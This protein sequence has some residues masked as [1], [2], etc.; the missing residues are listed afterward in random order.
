MLQ[1]KIGQID[2]YGFNGREH[3]PAE[4]D[5]GLV[6]RVLSAEVIYLEVEEVDLTSPL[7]DGEAIT[8]EMLE[9]FEP[10]D[11][12]TLKSRTV[13]VFYA[14]TD[15]HRLLEVMEHEVESITLVQE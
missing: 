3:A 5:K 8:R 1:I 6:C 9:G 15:D 13:A 7:N 4:S 2:H 11:Y 10:K 12:E 14:I